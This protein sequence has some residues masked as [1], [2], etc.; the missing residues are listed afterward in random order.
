MFEYEETFTEDSDVI[1]VKSSSGRGKYEIVS[2]TIEDKTATFTIDATVEV[3]EML[4]RAIAHN[5]ATF[6]ED[7]ANI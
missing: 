5:D 4:Q 6:D 2:I 7:V 1:T 3:V